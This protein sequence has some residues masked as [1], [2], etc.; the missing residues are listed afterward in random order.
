MYNSLYS[1]NKSGIFPAKHAADSLNMINGE[2]AFII[3][4]LMDGPRYG[5]LDDIACSYTAVRT[6]FRPVISNY[7]LQSM[8]DITIL[9]ACIWFYMVSC[10][11]P[12]VMPVVE[13]LLFTYL[14]RPNLSPT[15][16]RPAGRSESGHCRKVTDHVQR[17]LSAALVVQGVVCSVYCN[18]AVQLCSSLFYV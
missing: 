15:T 10:F 8:I 1:C 2:Y 3:L 17:D 11:P 7:V 12:Y 4:Q 14:N 9:Y 13:L 16:R 6:C 18:T 5:R